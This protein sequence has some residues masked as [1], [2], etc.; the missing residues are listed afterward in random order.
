MSLHPHDTYSKPIPPSA[1]LSTR[2]LAI[3]SVLQNEKFLRR[4]GLTL[5]DVRSRLLRLPEKFV[6]VFGRKVPT[7]G[8]IRRALTTLKSYGFAVEISAGKWGRR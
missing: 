1:I 4:E 5:H 3:L 7:L 2:E 8:C 6:P